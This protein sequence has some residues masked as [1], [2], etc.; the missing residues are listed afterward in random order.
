MRAIKHTVFW[1]PFLLLLAG[2][3]YSFVD[4]EGFLSTT[5]SANKWI[6][7]GFGPMFC[8]TALIMLI[9]VIIAFIS[10]L[11][12]VKIGGPSAT[13]ML[14]RWK[15]FSIM[16]CTTVAIG[17][18]FWAVA[19]PMFHLMTPPEFA[20]VSPGSPEA[21]EF[22]LSTMYL[23]WSFTPYAIYSVPSLVFALAYYNRGA[24]YSLGALVQPVFGYR[25]PARVGEGLD[26]VCLYSLVAG[27]AAAL[28]A[29]MLT[30][31]GGLHRL[32]SV[33]VGP[34]SLGL[35]GLAIVA[36]FVASSVSGLM[37]GIR[38]LSDWNAK[39]FFA[40]MIY[41]LLA[42]PTLYIFKLG[43]SASLQYLVDVIPRTAETGAGAD[44]D[45]INS[46]TVFYWAV[47]MAWAPVT[48][49]FL[50]R[51]GYG[52]SVREF[53]AFNF[54][55]PSLFSMVW[56]TVFSGAAIQLQLDGALDLYSVVSDGGVER[57]IYGLFGQLP[58]ADVIS[59]LFIGVSFL[60]FV[61]A[62]DSN[63]SAMGGISSTGISP[64]SQEAPI[65][66][67]ILWGV[68]VGIIAWVMV[69]FR[70]IDGIKMS[71]NLGGFPAM[72]VLLAV[73]AALLLMV[74]RHR[75]YTGENVSDGPQA[76][77]DS[78]GPKATTDSD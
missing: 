29:G 49:L 66:I 17:I 9:A 68:S 60:S 34:L 55:L 2:V 32:F 20:G 22:A 75:D 46:W 23:H 33:D 35:I 5:T 4:N 6:L 26:A 11:G 48:A 42:G 24:P 18:L 78:D 63:T 54:I 53:I 36:A 71:S 13:P 56:M 47:W 40:L 41:V 65:N 44:R 77:A 38:I 58:G 62:A 31:G 57:A 1:P 59:F 50:G 28:G 8:I 76:T 43:G 61:T 64:D 14:S 69:A 70:G 25:L 3:V 10:P 12:K 45:W 30:L 73:T 39:I 74:V 72:F 37:K 51:L 7:S 16:L 27:M 67:K 21:S 52:Y 19:E 15:W